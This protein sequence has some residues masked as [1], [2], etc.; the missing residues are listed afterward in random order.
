MNER[1]TV[2]RRPASYQDVLDAP[3]HMVAELIHGALHLHPR[4]APPHVI[5]GSSLGGEL[6]QPVP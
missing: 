6:F 2:I 3:P 4:P 1:A 5:A